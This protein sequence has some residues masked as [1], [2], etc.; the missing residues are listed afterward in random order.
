MSECT[1]NA[2]RTVAGLLNVIAFGRFV[3]FRMKLLFGAR[4]TILT[5]IAGLTVGRFTPFLAMFH[6]RTW[7]RS[8]R[9]S[10]K[11]KW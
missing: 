8:K 7:C 2:T 6:I 1:E 11:K 9:I 5:I 10:N 3:N 4:V